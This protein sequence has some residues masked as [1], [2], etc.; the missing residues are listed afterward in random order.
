MVGIKYLFYHKESAFLT[1]SA[2]WIMSFIS[3]FY[4][5]QHSSFSIS[6]NSCLTAF[7][8][9][10]GQFIDTEIPWNRWYNWFLVIVIIFLTLLAVA[11]LHLCFK[12]IF[13]GQTIQYIIKEGK[14]FQVCEGHVTLSDTG[15]L[16]AITAAS[17]RDSTVDASTLWSWL[18]VHLQIHTY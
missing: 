16:T 9:S 13:I 4:I 17:L 18:C 8:R 14:L 5:L 3:K 15:A 10:D 11:S 7:N 12:A 2:L 1:L 6:P